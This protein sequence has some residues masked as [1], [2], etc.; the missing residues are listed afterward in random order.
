MAFFSIST[1]GLQNTLPLLLLTLL[2]PQNVSIPK[3]SPVIVEY[4]PGCHIALHGKPASISAVCFWTNYSVFPR[5]IC[6]I[7]LMPPHR[8]ILANSTCS[9]T[10]KTVNK[11]IRWAVIFACI[12]IVINTTSILIYIDLGLLH[13]EICLKK[14]QRE[15][16]LGNKL[17]EY[18]VIAVDSES[19]WSTA[20]RLLSPNPTHPS[21]PSLSPYPYRSLNWVLKPP[22]CPVEETSSS[23]T[24]AE[25]CSF[26]INFVNSGFIQ[27]IQGFPSQEL[28]TP[29][30]SS[31]KYLSMETIGIH[32]LKWDMLLEGSD[33]IILIPPQCP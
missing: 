12:T 4:G 24:L 29:H 30:Y 2:Q 31:L 10:W 1:L 11:Y 19:T 33:A 13:G 7:E 8:I 18:H 21:E 22:L 28:Y 26:S 6:N 20:Q 25:F 27:S 16:K 32:A 3:K 17:E 9:T 5:L 14:C 23:L 15:P